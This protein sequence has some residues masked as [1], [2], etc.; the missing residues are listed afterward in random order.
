M[1]YGQGCPHCDNRGMV[2]AEVDPPELVAA[3]YAVRDDG[4]LIYMEDED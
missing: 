4:E 2:A 1:C 3:A